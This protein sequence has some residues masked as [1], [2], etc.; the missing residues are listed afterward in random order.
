MSS[1][2]KEKRNYLSRHFKYKVSCFEPTLTKIRHTVCQLSGV[3][4]RF[5]VYGPCLHM[6]RWKTS[7][8]QEIHYCCFRKLPTIK[9]LMV[10]KIMA[11]NTCDMIKNTQKHWIE[12]SS[13]YL[14]KWVSQIDKVIWLNFK[15]WFLRTLSGKK[16]D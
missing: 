9:K 3:S 5:Q 16:F 12:I 6:A 11:A 10:S 13:L 8:N 1:K 2:I 14:S 7:V 15:R 4:T